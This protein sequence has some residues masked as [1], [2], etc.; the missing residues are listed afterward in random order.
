MYNHYV[1]KAPQL[2]LFSIFKSRSVD[3]DWLKGTEMCEP[4]GLIF[5]SDKTLQPA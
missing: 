4:V 5:F 3:S 1:I 2:H